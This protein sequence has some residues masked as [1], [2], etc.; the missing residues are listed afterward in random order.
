MGMFW[1]AFL[2]ILPSAHAFTCDGTTTMIDGLEF[3]LSLLA[4]GALTFRGSR[5]WLYALSPCAPLSGATL[6]PPCAG[7]SLAYQ[8][9]TAASCF[10]L[11]RHA[12]NASLNSR[13]AAIRLVGGDGCGAGTQPRAITVELVCA[14]QLESALLS[15]EEDCGPCCYTAR[16]A[17]P[18]GCPVACPRAAGGDTL[19]CGGAQRGA[20]TIAPGPPPTATCICTGGSFG[21]ACELPR[22]AA[23]GGG[24]ATLLWGSAALLSAAGCLF[25]GRAR[26]PFYRAAIVAASVAPLAS[27]FY[28]GVPMA[29][30]PPLSPRPAAAPRGADAASLRALLAAARA[31][32]PLLDTPPAA[33][34]KALDA[35]RMGSAWA[36]ARAAPGI[37]CTLPIAGSPALTLSSMGPHAA[38]FWGR[39]D[40]GEW[41][42][43]TFLVYKHALAV[44]AGVVI[45]FG[46]WIG[47]TVLAAA[48]LPSTRVYGFEVDPVAFSQLAVNVAGNA[49]V[50]AKTEVLFIGIGNELGSRVF[51]SGACSTTM[52]DSCSSQIADPNNPSQRWEVSTLTLPQFVEA[53][54]ISLMDIS[55]IKIDTEGA[56]LFILP[57]L[58]A[59][60]SHWPGPKPSVWLSLHGKFL[61]EAP[62][63]QQ[64]VAEVM[65]LFTFGALCTPNSAKRPDRC[66]VVWRQAIDASGC[67]ES[68]QPPLNP[69]PHPPACLHDCSRCPS[70][71]QSHL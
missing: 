54:G 33:L 64:E 65:R 58:V 12:A 61:R 53:A 16:V 14:Q 3:D 55:L 15:V 28:R 22:V 67:V 5:G 1:C 43:T 62:L 46:S 52:G 9:T 45:D 29:E 7:S 47:P 20:C 40:R 44:R 13:G 2:C 60:F 59:W 38:E 69:P 51:G 50:A 11:A 70:N 35:L 21:A 10:S 36:E 4:G 57:T 23:A 68:S 42:P 37:N 24:A 18:A 49:A 41:E 27:L 63:W 32:H 34:Q 25:A 19:P 31:P 6:A 30:S 8:I 17:S 26:G 48:L 56:E 66:S 39:V 71:P